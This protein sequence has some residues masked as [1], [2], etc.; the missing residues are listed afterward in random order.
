MCPPREKPPGVGKCNDSA[1]G[2][3]Y[4]AGDLGVDP[5]CIDGDIDAYKTHK[6]SCNGQTQTLCAWPPAPY[7]STPPPPAPP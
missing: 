6:N 2:M 7:S 5:I 1:E 4:D 3:C